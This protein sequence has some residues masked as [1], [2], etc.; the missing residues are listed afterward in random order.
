MRAVLLTRLVAALVLLFPI[1]LT[2]AA[3]PPLAVSGRV[4]DDQGAAL[5]GAEVSLAPVPDPIERA[6]LELA[7]RA[8]PEPVAR[9]R[10]GVDGSY[11]LE[12]PKAGLYQ[13]LVSARERVPMRLSPLAVV[14]EIDV[15]PVRLARDAGGSV[16]VVDPA[17][18]PVAGA[19][20]STV[21]DSG[22]RR[23]WDRSAKW[24]TAPQW[25]VT[26]AAGRVAYARD[27]QTD[28]RIAALSAAHPA[29]VAEGLRETSAR[30]VL[31]DGIAREVEIRRGE[32]PAAGAAVWLETPRLALAIADEAGRATVPLPGKGGLQ[33]VASDARRGSVRARLRPLR[34]EEPERPQRLA[35]ER[36]RPIAG[37]VLD[38]ETRAPIAGAIVYDRAG[39]GG[40]AISDAGG[41]ALA[42]G[43]EADLPWIAGAARGYLP[44]APF[45]AIDL[46]SG[47][48]P[49]LALE[50]AA[51]IEG[52]V[53][54][55]AGAAVAGAE[56]VARP[57][58]QVGAGFSGFEEPGSVRAE[59]DAR[60][61]FRLRGLAASRD[62]ELSARKAGF[63]VARAMV[64]S[65]AAGRRRSGVRLILPLA[66]QLV[67]RILAGDESPI[68]GAQLELQPAAG[69]ARLRMLR[70]RT[71]KSE[72]P[73]AT[74]SGDG[75][76]AFG[77][78]GAGRFDLA[79][80]AA[81]FAPTKIPQIE[82]VSGEAVDLGEILLDPGV[83]VEGRV[84]DGRG[85]PV[86]GAEILLDA[87]AV[88]SGWEVPDP[89][90]VSSEDGRFE[91]PDRRPGERIDL[92]ARKAGYGTASRGGIV[93]PPEQPVR[94]EL[95]ALGRIS[96]RVLDARERPARA[97]VGAMV[98]FRMQSGAAGAMMGSR[99]VEPVATDDEGRFEIA[100]VPPGEVVLFATDDDGERAQK[101]GLELA[102][103]GALEGVELRFAGGARLV[104]RV[105]DPAGRPAR[106]ALIDLEG[107]APAPVAGASWP[108]DG[109][110]RFWIDG[111][112]A[113]R[114]TVIASK[115]PY[116]RAAREVE[117]GG[118]DTE[119]AVELQ[120]EAGLAV[121]GSVVDDQGA[122]AAEALVALGLVG[123]G[124]GQRP[125]ALARADGSFEIEG[126]DPGTYR[127]TAEKS[128]F[129][130]AELAEP[131]VVEAFDV[132]GVQLRL[133]RGGALFGHVTG[134]AFD[135]LAETRI[136][137]RAQSEFA[138][139]GP[140]Y[141]GAYRLEGLGPGEWT[142]VAEVVRSGRR[143]QAR[144]TLADP[145]GE[146][147]VD[148]EF[149]RGLVLSGV[150]L[151]R[152]EPV[153]GAWV[154]AS[155]G[156]SP[157]PASAQTDADGRFRLEG[158]AEGSYQV[159]AADGGGRAWALEQIELAADREIRLEL[160]SAVV[161]GTVRDSR[162]DR[163]VRGAE[164][165]VEPASGEPVYGMRVWSRE[166]HDRRRRRLPPRGSRPR[167]AAGAGERGGVRRGGAARH[168]RRP[169]P[170]RPR[171]LPARAERRGDGARARTERAA[172]GTGLGGG[173]RCRRR[174]G[175]ERLPGAGRGG[176]PAPHLA[177]ARGLD[178]PRRRPR[179]AGGEA[180]GQLAGRRGGDPPAVPRP[181]PRAGVG[182]RRGRALDAPADRRGR[183]A[184]RPP[185]RHG[186][187]GR[188]PDERTGDGDR[189]PAAR[190]LADRSDGGGRPALH[191]RGDGRRQRRGGGRDRVRRRLRR[192]RP[193]P[194]RCG[195]AGRWPRG[196]STRAR[197]GG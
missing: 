88:F 123:S 194:R 21:A 2:A 58:R 5:A 165:R 121:R 36:E 188:L 112:P 179:P 62:W 178:A 39:E 89:V 182:A 144:A 24:V 109:D 175:L 127:V 102:P 44:D 113:G 126:V 181:A 189:Q 148:L 104:G 138:A 196:R 128:G 180:A 47:Q 187:A 79:V 27:A 117:V 122:P 118:A 35:L 161:E 82:I 108:T 1:A 119:V 71:P 131:L 99:E 59:S 72:N 84:V 31:A 191:G 50:P 73:K 78:L 96:G 86:A 173:A 156:A 157:A 168:D 92:V 195:R 145:P 32:Q 61:S 52:V 153:D 41:Y 60:G 13:I 45:A 105:L 172:A 163:P 81:G 147:E 3:P 129:R 43:R 34:G 16:Q 87:R 141:E 30:L 98:L 193:A 40:W 162:D 107:S 65:L 11:R 91:V 124:R 80:E 74:S 54:D 134:L 152:G 37:R 130:R 55:S 4:L 90:A 185:L 76:F 7:G 33:V 70:P 158:L 42:L 38:A 67:G 66:G 75:T 166:R 48:G 197:R 83:S 154:S 170:G 94:L 69:E 93:V 14:D 22:S 125:T 116:R 177:A 10:S 110:G 146:V 29:V 77:S 28:Y 114:Y 140:D 56:V 19:R 63:G 103:G 120:L 171:R 150:V 137:A 68:S 9:A 97:T 100:G 143:A 106:D 155:G 26:D 6:R 95:P 190:A 49:S 135:D 164:V 12:A 23:S 192:L 85:A 64:D 46:A 133:A 176:A 184:L 139:G 57:Q 25:G 51:A 17:G 20:V 136:T 115:Q 142:L 160:A 149:G 18:A 169:R 111:V 8:A 53:V 174:R 15:E 183:R 151:R 101:E 159:R 167:R 132:D 186:G